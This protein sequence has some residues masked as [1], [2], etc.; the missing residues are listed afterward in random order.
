MILG[1]RGQV[2]AARH[3]RHKVAKQREK[4]KRKISSVLLY[5]TGVG[6]WRGG[7]ITKLL[8]CLFCVELNFKRNIHVDSDVCM[9]THM[10]IPKSC[11]YILPVYS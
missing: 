1:T 4:K 10:Y 5:L 7:K 11:Q 6:A 9:K 2:N 8:R 3:M